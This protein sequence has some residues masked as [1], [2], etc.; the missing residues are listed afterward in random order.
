[1]RPAL[2]AAFALLAAALPAR[3]DDEAGNREYVAAA[4][5]G[6]CE[7]RATPKHIYD[8]P[9]G[10]RQEGRTDVFRTDGG[11]RTLAIT[12]AWYS[13]RIILLC[14]AGG[15][16]LVVRTGPWPRGSVP[17]PDDL[18][19]A[20]YRNDR[21]LAR[22]STFDIA[23]GQEMDSR[24]YQISA[25]HYEVFDGEPTLE[26]PGDGKGWQVVGKTIDGRALSFDVETG[27]LR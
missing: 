22:Y 3:A 23:G 25:S 10:P 18:A 17:Y 8:P 14:P 26:A 5:V 15:D 20:F 1:M 2:L 7:A 19:L 4:A 11:K 13:Q 9:E 6:A 12:Y 24:S 16:V 27:R 21:E